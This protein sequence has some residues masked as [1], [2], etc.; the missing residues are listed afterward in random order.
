MGKCDFCNVDEEIPYRCNYCG[1]VFCA[2]HRL[3]ENHNCKGILKS[4][5][6]KRAIS[7]PQVNAKENITPVSEK[8]GKKIGVKTVF[9]AYFLLCLFSG[10]VMWEAS[11]TKGYDQGFTLGFEDGGKKGYQIGSDGG[12]AQGYEKGVSAGYNEGFH[13]GRRDGETVGH[14]E[15]YNAGEAIGYSQGFY[16]GNLT[17]YNIYQESYQN[18]LNDVENRAFN[19]KNPTSWEVWDFISSDS[20]DRLSYISGE[21]TCHDYSIRVKKNAFSAGYQCYYVC[22]EFTAPPG[23]AIIAFNTTDR[24]FI[25]IEPQLDEFVTLTIGKS[26]SGQ[27]NFVKIPGDIIERYLLVP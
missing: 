21:F 20:T 7:K 6:N 15:G 27:N 8:R 23:H 17:S 9:A 13:Q 18:G 5:Q 19:L 16:D 10:V 1:G 25:F 26:Y 22:I 2:H 3:P 12:Y 4:K 11:Y 24:G 14:Q